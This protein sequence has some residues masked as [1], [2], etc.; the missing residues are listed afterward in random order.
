[1]IFL[2]EC[3]LLLSKISPYKV[4]ERNQKRDR[5]DDESNRNGGLQLLEASPC[6]VAWEGGNVQLGK[7]KW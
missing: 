2:L 3:F 6:F 5:R 1:M 4:N 7:G